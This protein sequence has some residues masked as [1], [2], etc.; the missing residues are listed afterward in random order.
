MNTCFCRNRV[1]ADAVQC[2]QCAAFRVF[3]LEMGASEQEIK[4]AY[5]TLV[6]VWHPDRFQGDSALKEAAETKLKE[7]NSAFTI[8]SSA[9][10]TQWRCRQASPAPAGGEACR[11]SPKTESTVKRPRTR[12]TTGFVRPVWGFS[13]PRFPGFKSLFKYGLV[14]FAILLGGSVGVAFDVQD[15]AGSEVVR[16]YG[17]GKES[18]LRALETPKTSLQGAVERNLRSLHLR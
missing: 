10:S 16:A 5:H 14:A 8:L 18:V 7:I 1:Y 12:G 15:S 3:G 2:R 11:P 6:K 13:M 17:H 9:S 4:T